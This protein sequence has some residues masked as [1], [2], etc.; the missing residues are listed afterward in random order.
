MDIIEA[1][2]ARHAVRDYTDEPID[3]QT[4]DALRAAIDKANAEGD[5]DIQLVH[6]DADAF[7]GC[8]T[9]YGRFRNV[10]YCIALIGSDGKDPSSLDERAGYYGERLA[11]E[12][13]GLGLDTCWV[14]LH[15]PDEH[16][17]LWHIG[18]GGRMPAAIA[19]GH[20]AR[21]GRPHRS[22]PVE[23]LGAV[24]HTTGDGHG[25][26]DGSNGDGLAD[27]PEWFIR[28]LEAV[29]LAP[30]ALGKQ[31][32]RFTLCDD[33]RTVR[34][35]ALDGVQAEIGLGIAKLHFE[36]GAGTDRFTWT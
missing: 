17:G 22:K 26:D 14:V 7:G 30:S 3:G 12:A 25:T 24:E 6:D 11:L 5:L 16:D 34:A 19:I 21:A 9:H 4:L 8:P 28:G 33:S 27:A 18:D 32:F 15:D 2:G 20:G 36:L 35:E 10:R 1:M 29:Q 23:E 13:V 31:P